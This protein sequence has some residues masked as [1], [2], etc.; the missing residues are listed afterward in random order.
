MMNFI[1]AG[2]LLLAIIIHWIFLAEIRN[3]PDGLNSSRRH[4]WFF[5]LGACVYFL[6]WPYFLWR[7]V[8]GFLFWIPKRW[9]IP[10]ESAEGEWGWESLR[11]ELGIIISVFWGLWKSISYGFKSK[12]A[13][14]IDSLLQSAPWNLD[15]DDLETLIQLRDKVETKIREL[16]KLRNY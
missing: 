11:F 14:K 6:V 3:D 2:L 13:R 4:G 10:V 7:G 1:L 8:D 12:I 9:K 16:E 5:G 15:A